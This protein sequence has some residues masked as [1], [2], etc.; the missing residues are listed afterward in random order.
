MQVLLHR[1]VPD[2][3]HTMHADGIHEAMQLVSTSELLA[4]CP[5]LR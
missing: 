2:I 3:L 5:R 4:A 1:D